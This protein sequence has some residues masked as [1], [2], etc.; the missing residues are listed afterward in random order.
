MPGFWLGIQQCSNWCQF[1]ESIY[2]TGFWNVY[3]RPDKVKM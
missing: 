3:H 1:F 2:G